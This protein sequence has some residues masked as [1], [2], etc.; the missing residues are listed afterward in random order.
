MELKK[1]NDIL[2]VFD[3]PPIAE[4][5]PT[6]SKHD[7]S[8]VRIRYNGLGGIMVH[9]DTGRFKEYFVTNCKNEQE[10]FGQLLLLL[11]IDNDKFDRVIKV[12]TRF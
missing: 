5:G 10:L 2:E 8:P 11:P 3:F 4:L 7:V 12:L 6:I 1:I 9:I